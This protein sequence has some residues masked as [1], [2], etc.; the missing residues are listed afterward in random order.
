MDKYMTMKKKIWSLKETT[1]DGLE[2]YVLHWVF[3]TTTNPWDSKSYWL[4][5]PLQLTAIPSQQ[6][7]LPE[8][9]KG[10][11]E[12]SYSLEKALKE[13]EKRNSHRRVFSEGGEAGIPL[14]PERSRPSSSG[15]DSRSA[16]GE[17]YADWEETLR[18]TS[19][20]R[21]SSG[22]F[23]RRKIGGVRSRNHDWKIWKLFYWDGQKV[24]GRR[25]RSRGRIK[26]EKKKALL[27]CLLACLPGGAQLASSKVRE[28]CIRWLIHTYIAFGVL[29]LG[30]NVGEFFFFFWRLQISTSYHPTRKI[31][32][33]SF[34]SFSFLWYDT[35]YLYIILGRFLSFFLYFP[36]CG[37]IKIYINTG[38]CKL[39]FQLLISYVVVNW[40]YD[41][42]DISWSFLFTY[43]STCLSYHIQTHLI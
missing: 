29:Y 42:I 16:V 12:P 13:K 27:A 9:L 22:G 5:S 41:I 43:I 36:L 8:D 4:F 11:G 34:F 2:L 40:F 39:L 25:K 1:K 18:Q 28:W 24:D 6:T 30:A 23:L 15:P 32:K 19:M 14:L 3:P 17:R 33:L 7:Y 21:R 26:C 37:G 38:Y 35:K 20:D 31:Y 10:K